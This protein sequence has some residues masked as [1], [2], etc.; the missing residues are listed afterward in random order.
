MPK[1]ARAKRLSKEERT[2]LILQAAREVFEAEGYADAKVA[3]I[4]ARIGVVEGTVYSYFSSKRDLLDRLILD[5]Y[6]QQ[7]QTQ[8]VGLESIRSVSEKIRY[9]LRLHL[10]TMLDNHRFCALLLKESRGLDDHVMDTVHEMNREYTRHFR[11]LV[12]EGVESGA[13]SAGI[14]VSQVRNLL[15]GAAEHLFWDISYGQQ[16][17]DIDEAVDELLQMVF[18]GV[19]ASRP[20]AKV[21]NINSESE[22]KRLSRQID[23]L[24]R[25]LA[26]N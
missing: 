11:V 18:M 13:L 12:Q 21:K 20:S 8:Q 23:R 10:K 17:V 24:E 2:S 14:D 6:R 7:I 26:D 1:K 3:D 9:L 16:K 5:W 22:A 4:A 19:A 25:L 15:Y